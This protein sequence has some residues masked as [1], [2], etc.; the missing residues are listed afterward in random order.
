MK[1]Q[2]NMHQEKEEYKDLDLCF[3]RFLAELEKEPVSKIKAIELEQKFIKAIHRVPSAVGE[4]NLPSS[5]YARDSEIILDMEKLLREKH[6]FS[7]THMPQ[8]A[9]RWASGLALSAVGILFITIGFVLIVTPASAEFEIATIFYFN[10][11]DG[12]T[13]MDM[14]SLVLIFIGIYFFIRAFIAKDSQ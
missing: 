11:Y 7:L 13:V 1:N 3:E 9:A 8:N 2:L 12:F 4:S 5:A 6:T 14:F 10:E